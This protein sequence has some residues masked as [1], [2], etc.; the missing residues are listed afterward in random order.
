MQYSSMLLSITFIA[1]LLVFP[2]KADKENFKIFLCFGQSN[3]SGGAGIAPLEDL[4][5]TTD[6]VMAFAFNNC[7]QGGSASWQKDTWVPAR[8][9]L[10]CGDQG[11]GDQTM[12]PC[13]VFGKAMADSLPDDTIG[14]IP[15]G[16][17]GVN[18]EYFMKDGG[19]CKADYCVPYPGLQNIYEW[20]KDRCALAM[21]RGVLAGIVLHQGESNRGQTSWLKCVNKIYN[22]LKSDLNLEKDIPLVAGELLY[23]G[24]GSQQ[25][26]PI[27]AQI[28]DTV[29]F[30]YVA[31]AEGLQGGGTYATLH[32]NQSGY[33][34][35]GERMA[36]QMMK[37]LQEA[38]LI[39][40]THHQKRVLSSVKINL[41]SRNIHVYSLDG[42]MIL[43]G[44][45]K[46]SNM[47][48]TALKP[49]NIY[50]VKDQN[51]NNATKLMMIQTQ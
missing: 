18:I 9:P 42:R 8:E 29:P 27:I 25:H 24:E 4:K 20:M 43:S 46:N 31:S 45:P 49:G 26:N 30:G 41:S 40:S 10:H 23:A 39:T 3:I 47:L 34:K 1:S 36:V 44:S 50:I 6:R 38:N 19:G 35:M 5:Q 33:V 48:K 7:N 16:Q 22:D 28:P 32:F 13:Y 17:S 11:L 14:I 12:G 21:E 37:G 15:C 2:A 51:G